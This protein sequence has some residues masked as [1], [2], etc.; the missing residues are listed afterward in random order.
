[1]IIKFQKGIHF[2][3]SGKFLIALKKITYREKHF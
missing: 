1:M 2:L 3:K